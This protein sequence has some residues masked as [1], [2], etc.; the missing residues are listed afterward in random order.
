MA[1]DL[2]TLPNTSGK[3]VVAVTG[4]SDEAFKC[5][6]A[7][8]LEPTIQKTG[9]ITGNGSTANP[10]GISGGTAGQILTSNGVG[11]AT[12]QAPA[13]TFTC[14]SLNSC[15][16]DALADVDTSTNAPVGREALVWDVPTSTWIPEPQAE[17]IDLSCLSTVASPALIPNLSIVSAN[18]YLAGG[19]GAAYAI[20][21]ASHNALTN[22]LTLNGATEH[23]AAQIAG[24]GTCNNMVPSGGLWT[25]PTF[26]VS[27]TNTSSR[28]VYVRVTYQ[29]NISIRYTMNNTTSVPTFSPYINGIFQGDIGFGSS[30]LSIGANMAGG[31]V[32]K[33]EQSY[34]VL[35]G[36]TLTNTISGNVV[37]S[38]HTVIGVP[39]YCVNQIWYGFTRGVGL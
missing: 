19:I 37:T 11:Q 14:A 33:F 16:V 36:D 18:T 32:E 1:N 23:D 26:S 31:S 22:T 13:P 15:S 10:I 17:A 4:Y 20:K 27:W 35:P 25:V 38:G 2:I 29:L 6:G 24:N 39:T 28:T 12:F 21:S 34:Y 7:G 3:Q 30:Y 5:D 8:L 9:V